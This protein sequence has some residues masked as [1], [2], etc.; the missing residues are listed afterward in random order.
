MPDPI[1]MLKAMLAA[2][3]AAAAITIIHA[4]TGAKKPAWLSLGAILGA[5]VGF[6]LGCW[7]LGIQPNWPPR[8]DTDRFL[9]VLLPIVAVIELAAT[10]AGK[11]R[12]VAWP[13]RTLVAVA[14]ARVL[15]HDTVYVADKAGPG[16]REWTAEET[17]QFLGGLGAAL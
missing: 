6:S 8:E 9:F 5:M 10:H 4:L 12:W 11:W 13:L 14:A 15:L 16:S 17:W 3:L 2:A 1:L 7:L